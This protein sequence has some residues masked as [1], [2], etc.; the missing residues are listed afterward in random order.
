MTMDVL[1]DMLEQQKHFYEEVP[2]R[3][4]ASFSTFTQLILESTNKRCDSL[5]AE[6]QELKISLKYSRQDIDELKSDQKKHSAE[7]K[8]LAKQVLEIKSKKTVDSNDNL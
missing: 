5:M 4:E 6:I 8:D 3:Q 1:K 7:A 2:K